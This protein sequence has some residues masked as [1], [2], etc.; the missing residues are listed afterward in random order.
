MKVK[1][2]EQERLLITVLVVLLIVSKVG[3]A[4]QE[5][6]TNDKATLAIF[7]DFLAQITPIIFLF[8]CYLGIVRYVVPVIDALTWKASIQDIGKQI[9]RLVGWWFVFSY[10]VGPVN[11]FFCFYLGISYEDFPSNAFFHP[12]PLRNLFG[13]ISI[14]FPILLLYSGYVWLR[15]MIIKGFT[16]LENRAAYRTLIL[17][18]LTTFFFLFLAISF[19]LNI[20]KVTTLRGTDFWLMFFRYA[21]PIFLMGLISIYWLFPLKGKNAFFSFKFLKHLFVAL[22]ISILPSVLVELLYGGISAFICLG[23]FF[24]LVLPISWV[25]YQQR[26][27]SILALRGT[28]KELVK[29]KA[30]IQFLRSQINPHF[31]FNALNTL[32]GTAIVEKSERTAEGIQRL[33]DMMRFMLHDNHLDLIPMR[34]EID[35]LKNYIALQKLRIAASS[36]I[37]IEDTIAEEHCNHLIAPMLLIPFVE[38]AFKHGISFRAPSWIKIKLHCDAE[39]IYFTVSNSLHP[40]DQ[41]DPEKEASGIGIQNVKERL[42]LLYPNAYEFNCVKDEENFQIQLSIPA[43]TNIKDA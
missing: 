19:F 1:W 6:A 25:I 2:K 9:L 8:G 43:T 16:K 28:E 24:F 12:Q 27:D 32:Y 7:S 11:N 13:G 15:N 38:N 4:F 39:K 30:D 5:I 37:I 18:Q 20:F 23:L 35:Y 42:D 31:L 22:L 41:N 33:G 17:N 14:S 40:S 26:A 21:L 36:D 29:S 3:H 34:K 10:L